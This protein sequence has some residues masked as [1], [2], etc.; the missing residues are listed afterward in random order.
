MLQYQ[1]ITQNMDIADVE[2]SLPSVVTQVSRKEAR[3]IVEKGGEPVAAIVSM[4]DWR[5]L[6]RLEAE[7][8]ERFAVLERAR[9]AFA[10]VPDEEIEAEF[11][12]ALAETRAGANRD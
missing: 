12:R 9:A 3:V 2:D 5:K 1:P 6:A 10:D 7:R 8:E 4:E 11:D